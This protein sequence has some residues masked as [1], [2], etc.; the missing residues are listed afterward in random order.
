MQY[1]CKPIYKYLLTLFIISLFIFHQKTSLDIPEILLFSCVMTFF[2]V[3]MDFICI[4]DHPNICAHVNTN[5]TYGDDYYTDDD[6][7]DDYYDY[8]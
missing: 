5:N 7:D 6:N 4:E 8:Y 3:M 1:S 2:Y